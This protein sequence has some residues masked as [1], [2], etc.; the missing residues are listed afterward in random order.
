[1]R[2]RALVCGTLAI[3]L[4][5][6]GLA[7]RW[8]M[9]AQAAT[10]ADPVA[11][12]HRAA[13][14]P[15]SL[16]FERADFGD[17]AFL[18]PIVARARIV[19]IGEGQHDV[20][21]FLLLRNRVFRYLVEV[22][23]FTAIAAE[24]D[25]ADALLVDAYVQAEAPFNLDLV[26]DVFSFSPEGKQENRDLIEWLRRHNA[27][28]PPVHKVHFYGLDMMGR[29][30]CSDT[31]ERR[32]IDAALAFL[33]EHLPTESRALREKIEPLLPKATPALYKTLGAAERDLLTATISD[34]ESLLRRSRVELI[35]MTSRAAYDRAHQQA[36][37][38]R[39]VDADMRVGGW[40]REDSLNSADLRQR[41]AAM[42]DNALWVLGQ[43]GPEGRIAVFAHTG[44]VMADSVADDAY[45]AMG[46]HLRG[47][48]AKEYV[49][50]GS[51]F[52]GGTMGPSYC[53]REHP[54]SAPETLNAALA[55]VEGAVFGLDLNRLPSVG[56]VA[57]WYA[58]LRRIENRSATHPLRWYETHPRKAFD[59]MFFVRE[60][61]PAQVISWR[62]R[63]TLQSARDA[64]RK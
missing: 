54:V 46:E 27:S 32:A 30:C 41:D 44:H 59:A 57:D 43:Q 20:H 3:A 19:A 7:D 28:Q 17:L 63:Q 52:G 56:T 26:Q 25:F 2:S 50:L 14:V 33:R 45:V 40:L 16:E 15:V 47:V 48:L 31:P 1:M 21:Q 62:S 51:I 38:A 55:S 8:C 18:A 13:A 37:N 53:V 22:H 34:V 35:R 36:V 60:T 64:C 61:T 9:G 42:A 5:L 49:V 58:P 23:G 4:V 29:S 11:Q 39:R 24:T 12:W 6:V 10:A